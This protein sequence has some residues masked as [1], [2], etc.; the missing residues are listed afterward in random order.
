MILTLRGNVQVL[1]KKEKNQYTW[2]GYAAISG[3]LEVLKVVWF[4]L[5]LWSMKKSMY[6]ALNLNGIVT[7]FCIVSLQEQGQKEEFHTYITNVSCWL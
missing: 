5:V 2:K 6:L 7:L 4:R 3:A 1:Q